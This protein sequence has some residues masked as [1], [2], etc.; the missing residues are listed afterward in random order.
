MPLSP[1][2]APRPLVYGH[3][4]STPLGH[5]SG[6]HPSVQQVTAACRNNCR[7]VAAIQTLKRKRRCGEEAVAGGLTLARNHHHH[8]SPPHGQRERC[9]GG[10]V[11]CRCVC[12][13]T[14]RWRRA[15]MEVVGGG[16]RWWWCKQEGRCSD[17]RAGM[18]CV[19]VESKEKRYCRG[20]SPSGWGTAT[21]ELPLARANAGRGAGSRAIQP[22]LLKSLRV[23]EDEQ[24]QSA[25]L[26][27]IDACFHACLLLMTSKKI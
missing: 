5:P 1:I 6:V 13:Q 2:P 15:Y 18:L 25:A 11:Q 17:E 14:L 26:S 27:V 24:D 21:V 7:A 10:S 20:M 23:K 4:P 16:S 22:Q 8:P 12:G 3:K 19:S 9:A